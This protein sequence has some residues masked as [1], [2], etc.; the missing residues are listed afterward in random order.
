MLLRLCG[1]L[2]AWLL[3]SGCAEAPDSDYDPQ[4]RLALQTEEDPRLDAMST[5][6]AWYDSLFA[7]YDAPALAALDVDTTGAAAWVD[8]TLRGLTLE[9]KVGQL[10][11]VDVP[12]GGLRGLLQE[13]ADELVSDYHVGGFLVRRLMAPRDVFALTS[14]LQAASNVPLFFAADYER[15]V[16]RFSNALTELPANMALG[17]ARDTLLAAAAGRLTALEARAT[18]VNLLFAPVVDVNN[19][20]ENPIINIRSYGENPELVAAMASAFVRAAQ[21]HGVLTTLKHFPGHGDTEVDS[22]ARLGVVEGSRAAIDSVELRPYQRLMLEREAPAAVMTAHLWVPAL[23]DEPLPATFSRRI[24]TDLLRDSLGFDGVVVTDDVKMGALQNSYDLAERVVRPL[25]AGA[26]IVLTPD[27]VGAARDAVLAAV[28]SGRLTEA[29]VDRS[30][31]RVLAA[32]ARVGL[33]RRAAPSEGALDYLLAEPRGGVI[34]QQAA[35]EAVTVLKTAPV[36]PLQA[37][38]ETALVQLTNFEGSESIAAAMDYLQEA[39][40]VDDA[41]AM[42]FETAPSPERR[43]AVL[44]RAAEADVVVLALYLRLQ[45]GRGEAGLFPEQRALAE[46]LVA[47]G[48]PVVLVT[49]GNP[50]AASAFQEAE[51]VVVAYDQALSSVHAVARVLEGTL[52]PRGRLPIA[53][54][55]FPFGSGL[56]SVDAP[57]GG[58]ATSE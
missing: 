20:P 25:L 13:R 29:D 18:G 14:R 54:A 32:K 41:S 33:H 5:R 56:S 31:R 57:G 15:G 44:E 43:R 16:G 6:P 58:A 53:V 55:P 30:V 3:L 1:A 37:A 49:F 10:F 39:L 42:R 45:S 52:T 2:L 19:N 46:A 38:R 12:R 51:A 11:I 24:L 35:N 22:H 50:Y 4:D 48:T 7:A 47:Q 17:A 9:Q 23:E 21:R 40:A 27:A 26:D 36:L 8:A 34:A 28:A